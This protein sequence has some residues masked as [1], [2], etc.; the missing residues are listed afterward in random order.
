MYPLLGQLVKKWQSFAF[1]GKWQSA[2]T[3]CMNAWFS[4][5]EDNSFTEGQ[6]FYEFNCH[7][8]IKDIRPYSPSNVETPVYTCSTYSHNLDRDIYSFVKF[9]RNYCL[10]AYEIILIYVLVP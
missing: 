5:I 4:C 7:H 8:F 3:L 9:C 1:F 2:F 10:T 6:S